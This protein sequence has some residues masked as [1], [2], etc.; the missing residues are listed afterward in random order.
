MERLKVSSKKTLLLVIPA[1]A[2]MTMPGAEVIP[3]PP[4]SLPE[5]SWIFDDP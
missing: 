5:A 3:G 1:Q 4:R 2:G